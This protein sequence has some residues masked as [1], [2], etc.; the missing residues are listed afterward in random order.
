MWRS[1]PFWYGRFPRLTFTMRRLSRANPGREMAFLDALCDRARIGV[2]IGA[3][4]GMYTYR[5][6]ARSAEVIAFEPIPMFN[7][8]LKAVFD[9]KRGRIEPYA[10]S[11]QRGTATLRMPYDGKGT[12]Q[13]GRSTIDPAN[14]LKHEAVARTEELEVETRTLDEYELANVGFIKIDVEGHEIAV[15]EGAQRTIAASKPN[16]LIECNDDHQPQATAKLAAWLRAHEYAGYFADGKTLQPIEQYQH[17]EHWVK[18]GIENFMCVHQSRP[19]V[20]PALAAR[21]A[22]H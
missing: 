18:R 20:L 22:A 3:K 21:V 9:G 12:R 17:A 1:A 5:I 14:P 2:D 15:L 4:V 13:F 19:E 10:V 6:R 16:M 7:R 8:M 11:S